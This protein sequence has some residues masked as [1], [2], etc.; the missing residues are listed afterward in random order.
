[1][2]FLQCPH[3]RFNR[4]KRF[5]KVRVRVGIRVRLGSDVLPVNLVV[6][7]LLAMHVP[8]RSTGLIRSRGLTGS[9]LGL[10]LG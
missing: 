7:A 3:L 2:H 10:G 4:V 9:G 5:N 6:C 8:K 1:M